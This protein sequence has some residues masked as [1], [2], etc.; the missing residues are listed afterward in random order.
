MGLPA[1]LKNGLGI[2]LILADAALHGVALGTS[3]AAGV[4]IVVSGAI[5][6]VHGTSLANR[7]S[8]RWF[9]SA[10]ESGELCT[11]PSPDG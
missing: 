7:L 9:A 1:I 11:A 6:L 10:L 5:T 3:S 4:A 2:G 8:E